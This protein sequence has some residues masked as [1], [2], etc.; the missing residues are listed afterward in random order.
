MLFEIFFETSL[1]DE[2]FEKVIDE[3]TPYFVKTM[4]NAT[5]SACI[6]EGWNRFGGGKIIEVR[7]HSQYNNLLTTPEI[8]QEWFT[9]FKTSTY[10]CIRCEIEPM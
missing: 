5:G 8:I 9:G 1:N 4:E 6:V 7:L 2:Q 3:K 10:K